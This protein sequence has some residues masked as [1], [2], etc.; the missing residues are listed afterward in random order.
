MHIFS[1]LCVQIYYNSIYYLIDDSIT[2]YIM[3]SCITRAHM[4]THP[5]LSTSFSLSFHY[6]SLIIEVLKTV[7]FLTIAFR[8]T[9]TLLLYP[10]PPCNP[11]AFQHCQKKRRRAASPWF[12]PLR[13]SLLDAHTLHTS[14][15]VPCCC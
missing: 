14:F 2:T 12:N 3:S 1:F 5:T 9:L 8:C 15:F 4:P 11:T 7:Q 13:G 6:K 10:V